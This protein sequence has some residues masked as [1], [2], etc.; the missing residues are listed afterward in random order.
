MS[1][2]ILISA[3]FFGFGATTIGDTHGV[4][5]HQVELNPES[6]YITTFTTHVGLR[7]YKRL[8]FGI[9][10]AAE[11][12]QAII[13][14]SLDELQG[15]EHISDDIIIYGKDQAEHDFVSHFH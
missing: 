10:S 11:K 4:G 9:S 12:F 7:R 8:I 2:Q 5:Y 15:V 13:R 3:G 6:R 1:T 14:D